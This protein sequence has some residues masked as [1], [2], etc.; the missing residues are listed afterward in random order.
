MSRLFTWCVCIPPWWAAPGRSGR[1]WLGA[2]PA[3]WPG[4]S[5]PPLASS[6]T[7]SAGSPARRPHWPASCRRGWSWRS[8]TCAVCRLKACTLKTSLPGGGLH[9]SASPGGLTS[10]Y[11]T[12]PQRRIFINDDVWRRAF[13]CYGKEL[14]ARM[15]LTNTKINTWRCNMVQYMPKS[16]NP[17]PFGMNFNQ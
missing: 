3:T 1:S 15:N 6:P 8:C 10:Q 13:L 7:E 12:R 14:S 5:A 2:P 16:K 4:S 9:C 17:K 11:A